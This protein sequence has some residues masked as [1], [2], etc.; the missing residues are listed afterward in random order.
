MLGGICT[1]YRKE[2]CIMRWK[3]VSSAGYPYYIPTPND[4]RVELYQEFLKDFKITHI[5]ED[6]NIGKM[7]VFLDGGRSYNNTGKECILDNPPFD[8]HARI[9]KGEFGRYYVFH[10]YT[11]NLDEL[12]RWCNERDIIY[13]FCGADKS[14]YY[15]G[16]SY[17]VIMMSDV[18]WELATVFGFL[19]KYEYQGMER[20]FE[21]RIQNVRKETP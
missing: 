12:E 2:D 19:K 13:C 18:V 8:D 16:C 6:W 9:F 1:V 11:I 10:P 14:F 4:N 3:R 20:N 17:M 21:Y 15:P 7:G 5:A